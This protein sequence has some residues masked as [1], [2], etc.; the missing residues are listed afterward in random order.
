MNERLN[1]L[2]DSTD[3]N[4]TYVT[5]LRDTN[6]I[7][8]SVA[9]FKV[10]ALLDSGATLST[11]NHVIYNQLKTRSDIQLINCFRQCVLADGSTINLNTII[12]V[13]LRITNATFIVDLYVLVNN[14]I[15]M[16]IGCDILNK[17]RAVIDYNNQQFIVN[18]ETQ[19]KETIAS[20]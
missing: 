10:C 2:N 9:G 18:G 3:R 13:P 6:K 8:V 7:Y 19:N 15:D 5:S 11:I 4:D 12:R 16:I 17:L 14:H 1:V 20:L